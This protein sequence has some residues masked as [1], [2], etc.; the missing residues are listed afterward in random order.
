MEDRLLERV[1]NE[2]N[3]GASWRLLGRL[4]LER[5][6]V[7]GAI[8]ACD[9]ALQ[10]SPDNAS[11]HFDM[12]RSQMAANNNPLAIHHFEQASAIAPESEYA[13]EAEVFLTE[14][15]TATHN[16]SPSQ[17]DGDL[18]PNR[19]GGSPLG[20][21]KGNEQRRF[22]FR[23]DVGTV[24]NSNVQLA[25]VSRVVS[26]PGSAS[27]QGL[28]SPQLEY[29]FLSSPEWRAGTNLRGYFNFN[30][31]EFRQFDLQDY[32]SGAF[33]ERSFFQDW[34]ELVARTQYDFTLDE[35]A[36]STF[37]KRHA[38]TNV[39]SIHWQESVSSVY[40][41]IDHSNFRD[42]GVTPEIT[43]LDGWTNTL[44]FSHTKFF[45]LGCL[46]YLRGGIDVQW[47]PLIGDDFAYHGVFLY[48][49]EAIPLPWE[50]KLVLQ[51]GWGARQYP[52]FTSM[53]SRDENLW[54]ANIEWRKSIG[55]HW[56]FTGLLTLD[57][58]DCQ[59]DL[60]NT[61]RFLAGTMMT[62]RY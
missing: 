8:E 45:E 29:R 2:P 7:T 57:R 30:E 6:D 32:Q 37:G 22:D 61:N 50:S 27:I 9:H 4:R 23:L 43:S 31:S 5:N 39:L 13:N 12:A 52:E 35:F 42:D 28:L 41:T 1:A 34:G 26:S 19:F 56:V 62:Y 55:D 14:L 49:E 11:A 25:P 46:E 59:N 33:V 10:L 60:F 21:H 40:W 58:F 38:L 47:A 15:R 18:E 36:G 17:T 51:L 53:P 44:G 20:S 48:G 16:A 24:Y 3:D 54:R